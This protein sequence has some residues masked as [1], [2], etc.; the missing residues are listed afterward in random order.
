MLPEDE[1]G[2]G[3]SLGPQAGQDDLGLVAFMMHKLPE[4]VHQQQL[5]LLSRCMPMDQDQWKQ[6]WPTSTLQFCCDD[7]QDKVQMNLSRA[8]AAL[9][10]GC[11]L[12]SWHISRCIYW[13]RVTGP[14][15]A[16]DDVLHQQLQRICQ[17]LLPALPARSDQ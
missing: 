5:T 2:Q 11:T 8:S 7:S 1:A 13:N 15:A 16:I 3:W 9:E 4:G 10:C 6:N 12:I 14:L 17:W